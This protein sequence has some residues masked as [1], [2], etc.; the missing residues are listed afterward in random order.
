MADKKISALTSVSDS[1]IGA[2]DLLHIVDNPGGTPVNKKMTIGQLFENI[3]TH[4]A[5]D[6]IT[7]LSSTA[8]NLASSFASALD[9]SGAGAD[10]AFTLDNGTDTGQIKVI[11]AKTE[12][13]ST[14]AAK[15]T[16]ES[17][18]YSADST[19]QIT[20]DTLGDAVICF[21]DGS[22]WFPISNH[23]ATLS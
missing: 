14:Y 19:E 22:N 12:P 6:D 8:A 11:Y 9:L 7:N 21:W 2:D 5:I 20:L 16:V 10:V 4:L 17:W 18:G 15:I 1:D 13:A 23:G 3:P